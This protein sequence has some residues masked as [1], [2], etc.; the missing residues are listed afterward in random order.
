MKEKIVEKITQMTFFQKLHIS[1][2]GPKS[3]N[4]LDGVPKHIEDLRWEMQEGVGVII[5]QDNT[6]MVNRLAQKYLKKPKTTQVHLDEMGSY[7]WPLIDGKRTI[8][9]IANLV[10]LQFGEKAEPLYNRMVSYMKILKDNGFITID[11]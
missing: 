7:I 4:L 6:G 2:K 8:F 3:T 10:K 5:Y 9:E 11:V 1:K